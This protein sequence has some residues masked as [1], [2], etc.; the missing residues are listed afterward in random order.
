MWDAKRR[1]EHAKKE[2]VW[3]V[4]WEEERERK[5]EKRGFRFLSFFSL[6]VWSPLLNRQ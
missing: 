3:A 1:W 5:K 2:G 4:L 6:F